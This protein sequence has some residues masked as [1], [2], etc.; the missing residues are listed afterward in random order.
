MK[1]LIIALIG[2]VLISGCFKKSD[3]IPELNTN[4]YDEDYAGGI[5]F[6][7]DEYYAVYP[8]DTVPPFLRFKFRVKPENQSPSNE[9]KAGIEVVYN[10]NEFICS[11]AYIY[12]DTYNLTQGA[13]HCCSAGVIDPETGVKINE[14]ETCVYA[15]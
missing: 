2:C 8:N 14:F 12:F 11:E 10:G 6:E 7:F 9:I 13:Q 1:N 5:W 15:D 3:M 4:F